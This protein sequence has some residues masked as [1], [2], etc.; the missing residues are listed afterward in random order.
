M[1]NLIQQLRLE[2]NAKNKK[3]DLL[4]QAGDIVSITTLQYKN[5][6][7]KQVSKGICISNTKRV[8][9]TTIRLRNVIAG[10]AVEQTYILE[11]PIVNQVDVV[12]KTKGHF[13]AKKYYLREKNKSESKV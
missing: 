3:K 13:R 1:I 4:I 5:A 2:A 12:G 9:Y 6:K 11:S 8:G 10:E 7:R